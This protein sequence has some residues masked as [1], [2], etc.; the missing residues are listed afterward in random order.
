[1]QVNNGGILHEHVVLYVSESDWFST[2]NVWPI[3]KLRLPYL[4]S[5]LLELTVGEFSGVSVL[6]SAEK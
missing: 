6:Y 5:L 4:H 3:G 2:V 1:M